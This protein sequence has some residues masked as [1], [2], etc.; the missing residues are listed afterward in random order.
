[1]KLGG[2]YADPNETTTRDFPWQQSK[3][4]KLQTHPAYSL[5]KQLVKAWQQIPVVSV[6]LEA[7]SGEPL[8]PL[9]IFKLLL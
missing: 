5:S 7:E 3:M 8:K 2:M 4:S 1:M 6:T 9:N